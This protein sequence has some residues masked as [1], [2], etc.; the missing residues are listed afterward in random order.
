[1]HLIPGT[2]SASPSNRSAQIRRG[3][4]SVFSL[5]LNGE[6]YSTTSTSA[7]HASHKAQR[8]KRHSN[9]ST[10]RSNW[11]RQTEDICTTNGANIN[12]EPT[13]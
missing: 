5:G 7:S 8:P 3:Q 12:A 2:P 13:Q 11:K 1:M 9:P 6:I 4:R 10:C